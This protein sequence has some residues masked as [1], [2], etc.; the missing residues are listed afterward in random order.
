MYTVSEYV[1]TT[2]WFSIRCLQLAGLTLLCIGLWIRFDPRF[3]H[4][5]LIVDYAASNG[6]IDTAGAC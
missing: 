3:D 5:L 1:V 2:S 4:Y 6:R